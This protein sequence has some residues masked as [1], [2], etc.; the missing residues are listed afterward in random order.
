MTSRR[1]APGNRDGFALMAALWMTVV[2]GA[3]AY[4]LSARARS[5]RLAVANSLEAAEALAAA[6]GA[7]ETARAL[8]DARLMAPLESRLQIGRARGTGAPDVTDPWRDAPRLVRDTIVMG[9]ARAVIVLEDAGA[10]LDV[11]RAN[12]DELRRLLAAIP[13]DA[14]VAD[15]LAQ[16]I[17]DWRDADRV[18]R[19]RGAERGDYARAGARALP[20]DGEL[21][22]VDE[23]HGIEGMTPELYARIA[24]LLS[25]SG[26]LQVNVNAAPSAVLHALPGIG[27]EAAAVIVRERSRGAPIRSLAELSAL[28]GAAGREALTDAGFELERRITFDT[29][30]VAAHA[31]G[32][33]DGSPVRARGEA[34]FTRNGDALFVARQ[35][36]T[37]P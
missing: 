11:N 30:N 4:E 2:V 19:P 22:D 37:G 36:T 8:L 5:E 24:P 23:L 15:R 14:A 12:E 13:L 28:L 7:L 26:A 16:R 35:R 6:E 3:A 34:L 9:D 31:T 21:R 32:W 20:T 27:D 18:R 25:T 33:R 17:A 29:Q 10:R 1:R